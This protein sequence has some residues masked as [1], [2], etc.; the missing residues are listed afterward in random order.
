MLSAALTSAAGSSDYFLGGVVAYH[1]S[2]KTAL[3]GVPESLIA[4][5]G[6]VSA[7]VALS[8]AE[9]ARERFGAEVGVGITGIAGPGGGMLGKPVGTVWV[10][11][12]LARISGPVRTSHCLNLPG[13][14]RQVREAAVEQALRLLVELLA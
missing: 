3:L 2:A 13:D 5:E 10:A 1:N 12:S 14:R 4:S 6:A 8:M 7:A 11:L 9:G